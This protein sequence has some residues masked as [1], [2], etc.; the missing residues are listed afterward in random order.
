MKE[1]SNKDERLKMEMMV[2]SMGESPEKS[3]ERICKGNVFFGD[4]R[5]DLT[6]KKANFPE[7]TLV[8][9]S[10]GSVTPV[11]GRHAI[12]LEYVI[13]A[14]I[15]P[16]ANPLPEVD[17]DNHK[18]LDNEVLIFTPLYNTE[19]GLCRGL[20]K[21]LGNIILRGDLNETFFSHGFNKEMS[22]VLYCTQKQPLPNIFKCT[23]FKKHIQYLL[24]QNQEKDFSKMFMYLPSSLD[25]QE[26]LNQWSKYINLHPIDVNHEQLKV[27]NGN[28]D[29]QPVDLDNSSKRNKISKMFYSFMKEAAAASNHNLVRNS[30][31][32]LT[33]G[34]KI[35]PEF[36]FSWVNDSYSEMQQISVGILNFRT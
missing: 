2:A 32:F 33:N 10:N 36:T 12:Y 13:L 24:N 19:N 7:N 9:I 29:F 35:D 14:Q 30:N 6:I 1:A 16:V 22:K 11:K 31:A 28:E 4:Q 17:V 34:G 20:K 15:L 5:A 18:Y 26:E 3:T 21:R 23:A 27:L 25:R 8:Y